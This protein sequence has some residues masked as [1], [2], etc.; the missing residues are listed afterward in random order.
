MS[1]SAHSEQDEKLTDPPHLDWVDWPARRLPLRTGIVGVIIVSASLWAYLEH[2]AYGLLALLVLL[3]TAAPEL[4]PTKYR[5]TPTTVSIRNPFKVTTRPWA[6]F[7]QSQVSAFG[8]LLTYRSR[9]RILRR[10]RSVFLRCPGQKEEVIAYVNQ[11]LYP[12]K[13][14][15]R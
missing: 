12:L 10:V 15:P 7:E 5:L 14:D 11:H 2:P 1:I 8:V 9:V 13:A 4:F 6:A 3:S